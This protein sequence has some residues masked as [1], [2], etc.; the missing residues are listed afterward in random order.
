[1]D[2]TILQCSAKIPPLRSNFASV[3]QYNRCHSCYH[4]T[5]PTLIIYQDEQVNISDITALAAIVTVNSFAIEEEGEHLLK[6]IQETSPSHIITGMS[7]ILN[8]DESGKEDVE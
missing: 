6:K 7:S 2:Q 3:N 5:T 8:Q 1:M 4:Y